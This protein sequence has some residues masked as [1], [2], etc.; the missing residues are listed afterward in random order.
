[1]S[2]HKQDRIL[3]IVSAVIMFLLAV[4]LILAMINERAFSTPFLVKGVLVLLLFVTGIFLVF[5]GGKKTVSGK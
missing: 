1:M 2:R 3:S 5:G 4:F